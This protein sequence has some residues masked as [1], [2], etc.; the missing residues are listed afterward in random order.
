MNRGWEVTH[1]L[2]AGE[3]VGGKEETSVETLEIGW[4]AQECLPA[5]A[6]GHEIRVDLGFR[7]LEEPTEDAHSE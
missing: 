4:F 1:I 3:V 2:F 7:A 6:D 5:L